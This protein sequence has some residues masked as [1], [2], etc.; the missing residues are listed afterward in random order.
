MGDVDD[1]GVVLGVGDPADCIA[2][3]P[4]C[5]C[6]ACDRGSQDEIERLDHHLLCVVT[7]AFRRLGDGQRVI[8]FLDDREWSATGDISAAEVDRLRTDAD[9]WRELVGATWLTVR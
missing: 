8:T 1:A 7:G 5:G 2:W 6:D 4:N 3:L 9:G